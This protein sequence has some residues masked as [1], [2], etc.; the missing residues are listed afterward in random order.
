MFP[1][2]QFGGT[3]YTFQDFQLLSAEL[4]NGMLKSKPIALCVNVPCLI[5]FNSELNVKL[6]Q[7]ADT[8]RLP[9]DLALDSVENETAKK[10]S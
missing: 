2:H 3:R 5:E 4:D 1:A 9:L 8:V 10:P 6:E 7:L